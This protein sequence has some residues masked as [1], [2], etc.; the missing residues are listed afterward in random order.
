MAAEREREPPI[1]AWP[2]YAAA[3]L[4]LVA[5]VYAVCSGSGSGPMAR[6]R[7][8]ASGGPGG[9]AVVVVALSDTHGHHADVVVPP[10]DI[11]LFAGDFTRDG[12]GDPATTASFNRWLG[13]LPHAHK[14]VVAGNHENLAGLRAGLTNAVY[15]QDTLRTVAVRGEQV[16]I[17]GSPWQAQWS[18]FDTSIRKEDAAR[19]WAGVPEGLDV[20]L[21]HTPPLGQK[22]FLPEDGSSLAP[23]DVGDAALS[24]R[25]KSLAQP[26][27]L[28]VFGHIHAGA[29]KSWGKKYWQRG[30]TKRRTTLFANAAQSDDQGKLVGSPF[31]FRLVPGRFGYLW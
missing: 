4:L 17:Y 14:F 20:L 10:G 15:L 21:T 18:G 3:L 6:A 7:L 5:L 29:G 11:L 22:V 23:I 25:L 31:V 1:P 2:C 19:K 8:P 28:H 24:Q 9:P 13:E 26:P 27:L 30:A 12:R 16:R